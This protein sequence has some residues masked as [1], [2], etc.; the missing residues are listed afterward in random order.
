MVR[1]PSAW[2][3]SKAS[4]TY[5]DIRARFS[6][7]SHLGQ[8]GQDIFSV[9][10]GRQVSYS[11]TVKA[12]RLRYSLKADHPGKPCVEVKHHLSRHRIMLLI[13]QAILSKL[14]RQT[15]PPNLRQPISLRIDHGPDF[16]CENVED[17]VFVIVVAAVA[18]VALPTGRLAR[19]E[20]DINPFQMLPS[21][22]LHR[23][24]F[25]VFGELVGKASP[26]EVFTQTND[27]L[28]ERL[29]K[30]TELRHVRYRDCISGEGRSV[31]A[32]EAESSKRIWG[33]VFRMFVQDSFVHAS[34]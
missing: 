21:F 32:S 15:D 20:A 11:N 18:A 33:S 29:N 9:L 10:L 28:T 30:W 14:R 5:A 7:Q 24:V 34:S 27:P 17:G 16:V 4:A 3:T 19:R 23:K 13:L 1:P 22:G 8:G 2:C 6:G 31:F 26:L 12:F 25:D